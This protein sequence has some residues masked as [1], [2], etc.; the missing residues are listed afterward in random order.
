MRKVQQRELRQLVTLNS[1]TKKKTIGAGAQFTFSLL[2][3]QGQKPREWCHPLW[4]SLPLTMNLIKTVPHRH[5][6]GPIS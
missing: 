3:S 5:G 1:V 2:F 6:Q 4:V